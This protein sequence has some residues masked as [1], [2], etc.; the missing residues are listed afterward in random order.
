[1][2]PKRYR[3]STRE[4]RSF[5]NYEY[6]KT[7]TD[8][9]KIYFQKNVFNFPKF[10][11]ICKKDLFKKAV[12]RNKIKRRIHNAINKIIKGKKIGNF[13]FIIIPEKKEIETEKFSQLIEK[14]KKSFIKFMI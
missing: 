5:F 1:M 11:V 8:H 9:L 6:G 2:L 4:I 10:A 7:N 13:N 3:L 12:I 14:I